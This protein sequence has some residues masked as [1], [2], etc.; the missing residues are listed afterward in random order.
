[1]LEISESSSQSEHV[2]P[3]SE[4]KLFKRSATLARRK[5]MKGRGRGR[6]LEGSSSS[7]DGQF[8]NVTHIDE[9]KN[10]IDPA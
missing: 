3:P 4:N 2:H 1:M 5:D 9:R 10:E 6:V 8:K 7:S